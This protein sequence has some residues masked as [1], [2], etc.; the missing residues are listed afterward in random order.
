MPI[1]ISRLRRWFAAAAILVCV[2]VLGAYLYLRHRVHNAL[3][4]VPGKIGLNVQQSAQGFTISK[5]EQGRTLFKLQASKAIQFKQGGKVDLRQV[6]ITLYGRDSSRFDQV[7]GAEFEYDQPSGDVTSKGEVSIDLVSNPKGILNP[8][9]A[10]PR[11]LKNPI[12]LRTTDLVFN[13]KSG[14]AW[15][16]SLV[17][18]QV[19]QAKGS[20]MGARYVAKDAVLTL[21][22]QV[23]VAV[24]GSAPSSIFAD[25]AVLEKSPRQIV[26]RRP[27]AESADGHARAD[28][29]T[30][31]VR[32]DN[33]LEKSLA[34]GDVFFRRTGVQPGTLAAQ[35]VEVFMNERNAVQ[36]AILTGNV[37]LTSGAQ[38][39]GEMSAG[40]AEIRFDARSSPA[41]VHAEEQVKLTQK[42]QGSAGQVVEVTAPAMDFLLA[43]GNRLARAETAGPPEIFL[44]Q[45]DGKGEQTQI[46]ADKFTARFDSSGQL[47]SVHGAAGARVVTAP[48]AG[49]GAPH[50]ERVT[51]SD[52]IDAQFNSGTGLRSAI[53]QGNFTYTA[54][55][56]KAFADLARYTAADSTLTLSGSPRIVDAGM[57]TT[58]NSIRLNRATGDGLAQGQV[59]TTYSDLKPQPNGALLAS[60][61][62]VHV[63]AQKMAAHNSPAVATYSGGARLW[64]N[65]NVVEAPTIQ[66]QKEERLVVAD[67][68]P[69]QPVSMVLVANDQSGKATPVNVTSRHLHYRDS[70]RKAHFEGGVTVKG[71]DLTITAKQMDV[72]LATAS[73]PSQAGRAGTPVTALPQ[74][75]GAA[76]LE[77]IVATGSVLITEP[78]RRGTG[79]QLTYTA[80]DDKFV[81]TGGPPSIFDAE[82]GK[83]TGVSLTLFRRDGRVVVEGNSSSPAVT[84]TRVV[85]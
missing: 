71:A 25:E 30:L 63:T 73:S 17:E 85:R 60:S 18:F 62:P 22:S 8:D 20:A 40:K 3:K 7:Y 21:E 2:L 23:K 81:L 70:E 80:A 11:E 59:K 48:V 83:I 74:T 42:P 1:S 61:D 84:E 16:P 5:S 77:K 67:A 64:Q 26:L 44:F 4:E 37:H 32:E 43:G 56:Q 66:F 51:T 52:S 24:N 10:P 78:N 35:S 41:K 36:R 68:S 50:V 13:V 27:R 49:S 82:H 79:E 39:E 58:A 33:T 6:T 12:H 15:T 69:S 72:Y 76:R 46:T 28:E 31:Y 38:Q 75:S 47:A 19:P 45:A 55:T 54:G 34:T 29:L 57:M 14:D 53:Q 9:Q 65:A